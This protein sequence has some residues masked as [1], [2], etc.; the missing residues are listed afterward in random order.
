MLMALPEQTPATVPSVLRQAV[1]FKNASVLV[2]KAV[3]QGTFSQGLFL[4][5]WMFFRD[6]MCSSEVSSLAVLGQ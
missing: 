3:G 2:R 6:C 4:T 5:L 1:V